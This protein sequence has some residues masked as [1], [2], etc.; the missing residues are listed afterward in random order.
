MKQRIHIL[1]ASGSGTTTIA[2][3]ASEKLQYLH[4]DSDDYFWEKTSEPFT[5]ERDRTECLKIMKNEL[6]KQDNWILS[7]SL[8]GWGDVLIPFF[9]LVVF[10]YVPPKLRMERLRKREYER[11]GDRMNAGGDRFEKSREFIEWAEAY[12]IGTNNGR[13]LEKHRAWI[14]RIECPVLEVVNLNLE[15]SVEQVIASIVSR[16]TKNIRSCGKK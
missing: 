15:D 4:F 12:D 3:K 7:G 8:A 2:R 13:S 10:I 5:V 9:D 14:T 16:S 11:Y 1:G 6:E